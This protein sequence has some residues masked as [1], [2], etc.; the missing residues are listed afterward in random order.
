MCPVSEAFQLKIFLPYAAK[1]NN[2]PLINYSFLHFSNQALITERI[3]I[4]FDSTSTIVL[5]FPVMF[6][7]LYFLYNHE[8]KGK[9]IDIQYFIYL[10]SVN[11]LM[12]K[13][14]CRDPIMSFGKPVKIQFYL[15]NIDL[16][17]F[18][19]FFF[20][21]GHSFCIQLRVVRYLFVTAM[22]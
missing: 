1:N 10:F 13:C 5:L 6:L 9:K 21:I 15:S 4:R 7:I 17:T 12:E 18:F 16:P 19:F 2:V 22:G 8:G 11:V 20:N 3:Y 14:G